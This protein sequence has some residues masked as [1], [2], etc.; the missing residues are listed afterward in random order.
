MLK[1]F[2]K[3]QVH[4]PDTPKKLVQIGFRLDAARERSVTL[5]AAAAEAVSLQKTHDKIVSA[6]GA[7][8]M[9]EQTMA[10]EIGTRIDL[11]AILHELSRLTPRSI[12]LNSLRLARGDRTLTARPY[13]RAIQINQATGQTE[14]ESFISAL[15]ISPLF[16]DASLRNVERRFFAE[17][18]GERFE[19][20]F[21]AVAVP[22]PEISGITV[23]SGEEGVRR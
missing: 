23:A 9:L 7:M 18:A 13:G 8:R 2:E 3:N 11:R 6:I 22:D 19:A 1:T 12:K 20:S 4:G 10:T 14:V 15:K 21:E 17:G 16:R 5:Q